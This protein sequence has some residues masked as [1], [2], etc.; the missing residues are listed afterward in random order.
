MDARPLAVMLRPLG[1]GDFLTGVPAYR[2]IARAFPAHRIVLAASSV[3]APLIDLVGGID[4][5][6]PTQPLEPLEP[7]LHGADI[8]IDL[9]GRGPASH[10]ILAASRPRRLISFYNAELAPA[11]GYPRWRA[12]EH[13]IDRWC[14]L[15][16]Q[17]GIPADPGDLEL[18][19]RLGRMPV[20]M[21]NVTVIH[22][23]AASESR[24][25]PVERWAAVARAEQARGRVVALTGS[26]TERGRA[27]DIADRA[28]ISRAQV[29]AGRTDL[30]QLAELVAS[31]G[32]VVCGDT[33]VAHLATALQIPSV[34]LF[35]PMPPALW[36]PPPGRPI[37]RVL[38]TG[39]RGDPHGTAV[40]PGLLEIRAADVIAELSRL[41][42]FVPAAAAAAFGP[43]AATAA[44]VSPAPGLR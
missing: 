6:V 16:A 43:C 13:E 33:G 24:R 12:D 39:G 18:R 30:R 10:R 29:V 25:W 41:D 8:A 34:L 17:T 37:H 2:A 38:W 11:P 3:F 44:A 14:R 22:A 1:L 35:G 23:S 19:A 32:R 27:V 5:L 26:S 31:A 9:H 21:P 40:D 20:R 7:S 15:L 4:A 42:A 36:G 28:G